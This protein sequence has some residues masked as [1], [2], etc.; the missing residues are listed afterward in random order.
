VVGPQ[1]TAALTASE[2]QQTFTIGSCNHR[3]ETDPV[4]QDGVN[5]N[6]LLINPSHG[7]GTLRVDGGA[8]GDGIELN[9]TIDSI[10][11]ASRMSSR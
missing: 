3:G 11:R 10:E 6:T 8:T 4:L 1:T 9:G 7:A 2:H 5:G